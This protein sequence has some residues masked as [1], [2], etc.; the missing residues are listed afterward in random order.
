MRYSSVVTYFH[1]V[2]HGHRV[3]GLPG[4]S[5]SNPLIKGVLLG[6]LN[7][8]SGPSRPKDPIRLSDLRKLFGVLPPDSEIHLIV[9]IALLVMY[10]TLLRVSHEIL[11]P[12]TL[13]R[14][15]LTFQAWGATLHIKSAKNLRRSPLGVK[16]PIV[17]SPSSGICPVYWLKKLVTK[18]PRR[19]LAPLFSSSR[20]KFLSYY[21]FSSIFNSLC[22]RAELSGNFASHSL[23]RG[24]ASAMI[25]LGIPISDVKDRGL[26]LSNC[27]EKYLHPSDF[28]M[29][30]TDQTFTSLF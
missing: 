24:G 19:Q 22:K 14:A 29:R 25:E 11:S 5:V 12:H 6:L 28:H 4:P 13:T 10:R 2:T 16:I 21:K 8:P 7:D 18:F 9:W 17:A 30:N 3:L 23:R 20:W 15:D 27:V 1:A 26:W